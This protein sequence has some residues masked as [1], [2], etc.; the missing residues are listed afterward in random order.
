MATRGGASVPLDASAEE[1]DLQSWAHV[2]AAVIVIAAAPALAETPRVVAYTIENGVRIKH[3]LTGE[4]GTPSAGR[5]LFIDTAATGCALCHGDPEGAPGEARAL[6]GLGARMDA[7]TIRLWLVAPA[8][9][10]PDTDMPSYYEI[11]QRD[12][13]KDPFFGQTRL[14][15]AEIE[16]LVAYLSSL[17]SGTTPPSV[18]GN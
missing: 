14:S 10:S 12:D 11:G 8:I 15:A 2:I 5:E 18:T 13:P 6:D 7:G 16:D 1:H 9:L 17:G 3:S 4:P